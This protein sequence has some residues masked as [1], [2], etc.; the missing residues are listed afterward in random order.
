MT[1]AKKLRKG[2]VWLSSCD[3]KLSPV[4][5]RYGACQLRPHKNHYAGLVSAI[6]SQ[7]LSAKA[8][9]TIWQRVLDIF[10]GN[11]PAP[12]QLVEVD[13]EVLRA[14]GV[15]YAKVAYMKDLAEH[16]IDG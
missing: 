16:I 5:K 8:G 2:E 13:T 1:F 14:C 9:D 3:K 15:S 11:M 12:E 10:G 6:V 4:I 7:Q